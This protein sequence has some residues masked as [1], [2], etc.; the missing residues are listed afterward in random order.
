MGSAKLPDQ[1]MVMLLALTASCAAP[2]PQR[3]PVPDRDPVLGRLP[4]D[5]ASRVTRIWHFEEQTR[6]P[7]A[8]IPR[9]PPGNTMEP[10]SESSGGALAA[11][12]CGATLAAVEAVASDL[13]RL[14]GGCDACIGTCKRRHP[15]SAEQCRRRCDFASASDFQRDVQRA[16]DRL[17]AN[18]E[19][20]GDWRSVLALRA[21]TPESD[22]ELSRCK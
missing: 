2:R 20:F 13:I 15:K 16:G 18:D 8:T 14:Y 3:T 5:V 11:A 7:V 22:G 1:L 12:E 19:G 10:S 17:G 6:C 21:G 9:E 4:P